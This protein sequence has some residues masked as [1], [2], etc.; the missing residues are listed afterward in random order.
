MKSNQPIVFI[1]QD[2]LIGEMDGNS[3]AEKQKTGRRA[4]F[5]VERKQL[6]QRLLQPHQRPDGQPARRTP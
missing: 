5:L 2:A 1:S 3:D 6:I 4:R